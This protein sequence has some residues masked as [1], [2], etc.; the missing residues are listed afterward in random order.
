MLRQASAPAVPVQHPKSSAWQ[1]LLLLTALLALVLYPLSEAHAARGVVLLLMVLVWVLALL[2]PPPVAARGISS[3]SWVALSGLMLWEAW[4]QAD[5]SAWALPLATWLSLTLGLAMLHLLAH[6]Q[7]NCQRDFEQQ[8]SALSASFHKITELATH[9][10]LTGLSNRR[11]LL[12]LMAREQQRQSRTHAPLC[13]AMLDLDHFKRVNDAHGHAAGDTVLKIFAHILRQ[14]LRTTDEIARWGGEEFLLLM[15]HTHVQEA[16]LAVERLRQALATA[17][18][19]PVPLSTPV[20]FS[21]GIVPACE[22][23]DMD[24]IIACADEAM[25]RA[26]TSGRNCSVVQDAREAPA[27]EVQSTQAHSLAFDGLELSS[28]PVQPRVL[29]VSA[30]L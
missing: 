9:D 6:R 2:G 20:T 3:V 13:V 29:P 4:V 25:Y 16:H 8:A 17:S 30:M 22:G 21:A 7:A 23:G 1:A 19:A 26:K 28:A 27:D 12:E 10:E 5:P 15:P 14:T 11:H 24:A 18:F